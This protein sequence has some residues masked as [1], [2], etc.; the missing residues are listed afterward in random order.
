MTPTRD[1][2]PVRIEI[3]FAAESPFYADWEGKWR[4]GE[5]P[6][7]WPYGLDKL[8]DYADEVS[9]AYVK[10]A[11]RW[12][13]M[14]RPLTDRV[15]NAAARRR[16]GRDIGLTWDEQVAIRMVTSRRHAEMY[17]GA[18]WIADRI[19]RG[20]HE[21][22]ELM[23]GA[24]K[25]TTG[26]WLNSGPHLEPMRQIVG[27]GPRLQFATFGIDE[28]FFVPEPLPPVPCVLSIGTDRD[29]DWKTLLDAYAL[30]HEAMP[31]AELLTQIDSRS[32]VPVPDFV[33]QL[34][35]MDFA[36]LRATYARASVVA[37]A[38]RHNLHVSGLTVSLE[39]RATGRPFVATRTVGMEDFLTDG[40]DCSLVPIGDARALADEILRLLRDR[41]AAEA[42]GRAGREQILDH[43][44]TTALVAD[45]ARLMGLPK[46]DTPG[47]VVVRGIV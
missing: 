33:R 11:R 35:R 39:A 16:P 34:P 20:E 29:R 25:E 12:R 2:G 5:R 38:M 3:I 45:I 44:T 7:R 36:E 43:L 22:N 42:M 15:L 28:T 46:R 19:E 1:A 26:I 27:P 4:R 24:L 40:L 17:S 18:I 9:L 41:Q 21:H 47:R 13:R 14:I 31:E 32:D 30:V 8:A 37:V 23:I 10:R 6:S